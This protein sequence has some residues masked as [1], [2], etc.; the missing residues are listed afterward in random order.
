MNDEKFKE[1]TKAEFDV[2]VAKHPHIETHDIR[3][4]EPPL[5]FF[6]FDRCKIGED[7]SF[8]RGASA[9]VDWDYDSHQIHGP[10][11]KYYVLK[12]LL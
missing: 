9:C 2:V 6:W 7:R 1:V 11:S 8:G 10:A 4:R 5:T 3:F 12:E